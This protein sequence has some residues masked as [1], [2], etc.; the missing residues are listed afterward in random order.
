[1]YEAR[2]RSHGRKFLWIIHDA[3]VEPTAFNPERT[4]RQAARDMGVEVFEIADASR[5][6]ASVYQ[7]DGFHLNERGALRYTSDLSTELLRRYRRQ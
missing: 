6:P 5:Y 7:D 1:M 3:G 2:G 4:W